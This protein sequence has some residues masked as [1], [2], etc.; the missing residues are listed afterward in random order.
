MAIRS[1]SGNTLFQRVLDSVKKF[2]IIRTLGLY[3]QTGRE[4]KN[5]NFV[6]K[7]LELAEKQDEIKVVNDQYLTPTYTLD[8]AERIAKITHLEHLK[9]MFPSKI[10]GIWHITNSGSYSWYDF[11]KEIIG[12]CKLKAKVKIVPIS[13]KKF[14]VKAKR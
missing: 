3:G 13:S 2:I 5:G 8:L 1:L 14:G 10:Y 9:K 7:I 12:L 6:E 4:S 11:A